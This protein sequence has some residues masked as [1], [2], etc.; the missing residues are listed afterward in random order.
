[1]EIV[2]PRLWP[3]FCCGS[4]KG[5]R[6]TLSDGPMSDGPMSDGDVCLRG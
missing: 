3:Q 1:M 6:C 4:Q 2:V 5:I